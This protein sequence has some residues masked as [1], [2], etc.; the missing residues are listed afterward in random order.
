MI[1]NLD[2]VFFKKTN[3]KIII[4]QIIISL[5]WKIVY[6]LSLRFGL[7]KNLYPR[8]IY[9]VMIE[10]VKISSTNVSMFNGKAITS[11]FIMLSQI[12]FR[13][14]NPQQIY[15]LRTHYTI[16]HNTEWNFLNRNNRISKNEKLQF[17]VDK[18]REVLKSVVI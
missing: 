7:F 4:F 5:F 3:K 13:I 2:A 10:P 11:I 6:L 17:N 8:D 16:K 12:Y 15:S 1:I 9:L 18:T 14:K